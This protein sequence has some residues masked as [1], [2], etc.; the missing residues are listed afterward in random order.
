MRCLAESQRVRSELPP[1]R[2]RAREDRCRQ[3]FGAE[4]R[5]ACIARILAGE[6]DRLL[7][8]VGPCYVL[9][10]DQALSFAPRLQ[11]FAASVDDALLVVMCT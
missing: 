1:H 3:G 2:Q 11:A 10:H 5:P 8:D 9:D 7:A 4:T 6:D